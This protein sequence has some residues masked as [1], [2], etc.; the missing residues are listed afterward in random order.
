M[1]MAL[2][3]RVADIEDSSMSK[4]I[5]IR[6]RGEL[7]SIGEHYRMAL[8][9]IEKNNARIEQL[10]HSLHGVKADREFLLNQIKHHKRTLQ[11]KT[12]V[13]N[14]LYAAAKEVLVDPSK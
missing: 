6:L 5:E 3:L 1:Q 12:T 10:E 2:G 11:H 4:A 8:D 7:K 14:Q 13:D 9:I